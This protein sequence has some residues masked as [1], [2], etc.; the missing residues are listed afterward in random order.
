[1]EDGI[2]PVNLFSFRYNFSSF[3]AKVRAVKGTE[4][5]KKLNPKSRNF[6]DVR[7][8]NVSSKVHTGPFNML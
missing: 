7:F 4:P 5:E 2:D 3:V 1:M 8:L 6:K